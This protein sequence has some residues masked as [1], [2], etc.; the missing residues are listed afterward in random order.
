MISTQ[1]L[2]S[3]ALAI[4]DGRKDTDKVKLH[5]SQKKQAIKRQPTLLEFCSYVWFFQGIIAGPPCFYND[6]IEFIDGS[7]IS[8]YAK[9]DDNSSSSAEPAL[10]VRSV[11]L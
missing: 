11:L 8:K 3:F 4:Y 10:A 9:R 1:K 5:E 2:T 7:N 6:Y